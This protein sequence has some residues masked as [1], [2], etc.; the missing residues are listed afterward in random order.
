MFDQKNTTINPTINPR[1]TNPK[2]SEELLDDEKIAIHTMQDDINALSGIFPKEKEAKAP[3]N[4]IKVE[5]NEESKENPKN[6]R[7]FNPFLDK[8]TPLVQNKATNFPVKNN[9]SENIPIKKEANASGNSNKVNN[10]NSNKFSKKIIWIAIGIIIA[11]VSFYGGYYFWMKKQSSVPVAE[12]NSEITPALTKEQE[13][14]KTEKTKQENLQSIPKYSSD[15]PNFLSIDI[16]NPSYEN[17]K[18]VLSKTALEIKELGIKEPVEFIVTG[19][20]LSPI[21]FSM[22]K[23]ISNIKLSDDLAKNLGDKFS[24]F[25]YH[26]TGNVRIGLSIDV[27][28]QAKASTLIKNEELKLVEELYPLFL[29]DV[30]VPKEKMVFRDNNYKG[31]DIRYFN[32]TSDQQT[33][34]DYA[35]TK[36]QLIIGMSKNTAWVIIDK[37]LEGIK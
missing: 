5:N 26:N 1:S 8:Q 6:E 25:V 35:L 34:V 3:S 17:F 29:E 19:K 28:D 13:E 20:D 11:G 12:K 21:S 32:L 22:F 36:N 30:I 15:K 23:V 18:S 27:T 33:T 9:V 37:V 7:Y 31:V 16:E 10:L 2:K 24:L 4:P 14:D